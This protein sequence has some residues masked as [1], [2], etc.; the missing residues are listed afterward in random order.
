MFQRPPDERVEL[1]ETL[2]FIDVLDTGRDAMSRQRGEQL[3]QVEVRGR[4]RGIDV[5]GL[6][7]D[8][9]GDDR[10]A[11]DD[12]R[13]LPEGVERRGQSL[14]RS[15]EGA[16]GLPTRATARRLSTQRRRSA[17]STREL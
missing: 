4:H 10:N 15:Q 8:T 12:H 2:R 3:L 11:A 9:T 7:G 17:F 14:Q 5:D 1:A 16:V 13:G 6:P